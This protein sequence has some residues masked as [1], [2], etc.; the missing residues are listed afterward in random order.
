MAESL[1]EAGEVGGAGQVFKDLF[2]GAVGGIA[3]VLIGKRDS[4]GLDCEES[5]RAWRD[6]C[7]LTGYCRSTIR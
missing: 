1:E 3:Q 2:S 4:P 6:T 5:R 7:R